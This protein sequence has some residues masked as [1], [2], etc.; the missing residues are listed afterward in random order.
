MGPGDEPARKPRGRR[1]QT[2]EVPLANCRELDRDSEVPLYYQL[3]ATLLEALEAGPWKEDA[4]FATEREL[5]ERFGVSRVVVARAL[6]LLV[7]DGAIV[8]RKGAGTFLAPRRKRISV[9]GLVKALSNDAADTSVKIFRIR[10]EAPDAAVAKFLEVEAAETRV[11]QT[12]ARLERGGKPLGLIDSHVPISHL[13]WMP[14]AVQALS[15]GEEADPGRVGLTRSEVIV[16]HTFFG[17]WG[18][19]KLGVKAGDPA[20]MV[21]LVQFGATSPGKPE[22]PLEFAR[23]FF[24][25]RTTQIGFTLEH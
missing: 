23:L 14:A 1:K 18:G 6:G 15:E 17:S 16:E 5:E 12:T 11:C 2:S 24:P 10:E 25:A 4:R 8:R 22:R 9:F 19:P 20:L 3:G 21:R 13:P 7:G